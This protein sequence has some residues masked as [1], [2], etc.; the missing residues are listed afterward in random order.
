MGNV[1]TAGARG[2][3]WA[4]GLASAG[5]VLAAFGHT[6]AGGSAG[7]AGAVRG[8]ILVGYGSNESSAAS[9]APGTADQLVPGA[10]GRAV[11]SSFSIAG[12]VTGLYPGKT[13][14]LVLTVT[15]PQKVTITV[16]S[17]TTAV[18][19]AT[20]SCTAA[21][22]KVSAFSGSLVVAAGKTGKVSVNVTL[23]HT[24]PNAC[25]GK[26]FPFHYT[27]IAH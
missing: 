15:N 10:G 20:T 19:N 2:V 4:A 8:G 27:G 26:T 9:P 21:N 1:T 18:S 14:P 6:A 13:L 7:A 17:I 22:V 23:L 25:Q 3:R 12:K 24:T 5:L 11:T 16:T